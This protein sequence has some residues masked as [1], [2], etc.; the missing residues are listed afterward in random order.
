VAAVILSASLSMLRSLK[1]KDHISTW[2]LF[3]GALLL[4]ASGVTAVYILLTGALAG[5][6]IAWREV[7]HHAG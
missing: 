7:K 2:V 1:R 6:L 3:A 5:I 4:S